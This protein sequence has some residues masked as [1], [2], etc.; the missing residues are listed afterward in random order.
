VNN[1]YREKILNHLPF[2]LTGAQK[3]C[4]DDIDT[5]MA[6]PLRMLRL[7]QGDVGSG[8][9]VVAALAMMNVID[10]GAQAA[11]MAPTEILARQH[12]ESFGE[13]LDAA[14]VSYVTL[15]GRN[16]SKERREILEK[17]ENG[18]AQ[19]V[20]GTH[21]LFQESVTFHNLGLAVIDLRPM[22]IWKLAVLMK[23]HPGVNLLIRCYFPK[24]KLMR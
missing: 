6:E 1:P 15:T 2:E 24:K 8:K 5:D 17:I 13:W 20:I 19:V 12:E 14:G 3:R 22:A 10:G 16:K 23:N 9:T 18:E 4:L 21:A 7:V 11:I